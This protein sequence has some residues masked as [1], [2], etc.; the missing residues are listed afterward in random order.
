MCFSQS[1]SPCSALI[2]EQPESHRHDI[3][4]LGKLLG[5]NVLS[6]LWDRR[7]ERNSPARYHLEG[8]G[9]INSVEFV[10]SP[11]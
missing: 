9:K 7:P 6:V 2:R 8:I 4:T 5:R 11:G 1:A 10:W 3:A